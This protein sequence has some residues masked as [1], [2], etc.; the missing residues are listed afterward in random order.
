MTVA[1]P[2]AKPIADAELEALFAALPAH[3]IDTVMLAVSGGTDSLAML[4][5]YA[6]FASHGACPGRAL[7]ATVDH[8][9]RPQSAAEAAFV[10]S[11][12]A[13][14]GLPHETLVW[15]GVK[16]ATGRQEAARD[17]R[18]ALL[19]E[20]LAREPG[21]R[22]ALLTAHTADDQAETLLMRLA[23]GS[24][25]DGLASITPVRSLEPGG[26]ILLI[27]PL[28]A[29]PRARLAATVAAAGLVPV[30]DPSNADPT[31]ERSRM[32]SALYNLAP[33]GLTS[34]AL[35]RSATRL[36]R[37]K[38]A[39]EAAAVH[40][41]GEVAAVKPGLC[42]SFDRTAYVAAPE[43]LRIRLLARALNRHRGAHPK[44][45]LAQIES[46]AAALIEETPNAPRARTVGGCVIE[47]RGNS[48]TILRELGRDRLAEITLEP[49][50]TL[51]WDERFEV[52]LSS[53][54]PAPVSVRAL[55]A[56]VWPVIKAG[57][58]GAGL[59]AA[60]ARTLPSFW[61]DGR[62]V[63]LPSPRVFGSD[64]CERHIACMPPSVTADRPPSA[65]ECLEAGHCTLCVSHL[66]E[67]A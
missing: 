3:A 47:W 23:R 67:Q 7:V 25:L 2:S 42:T 10:A 46:L 27:R 50:A 45:E 41:E 11:Q 30:D 58:A 31:Y 16:P 64:P 56:A 65:S 1:D 29:M 38:A 24:S 48:I 61:R 37:A 52:A 62:L 19:G 26:E 44:A 9:L 57:Y 34:T 28:L 5:L 59:S 6:R 40:L 12:A 35:A 54:A 8:G 17:A 43:E 66:A 20:R 21:A 32:R 51:M 36:Q 22:R 55:P 60:L 33:L 18:Y 15:A 4:H 63:A 14:L 39:L 13:A 49:G 53:S